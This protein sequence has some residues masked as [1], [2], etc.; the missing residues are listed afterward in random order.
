[1]KILINETFKEPENAFISIMDR[2][3]L[4]GDGVYEVI[5]YFEKGGFVGFNPHIKRLKTGL[6]LIDI[7]HPKLNDYPWRE[8]SKK[9]IDENK[10]MGDNLAIYIQVTRGPDATRSHIINPNSEPTVIM[11]PLK[12]YSIDIEATK[13]GFSVITNE[14]T[15]WNCNFIKSI[16]LLSNA[17]HKYQSQKH[18][19]EETLLVRA[20][21]AM[22]G[23]SSNVFIAKDGV[24]I[25]PPQSSNIL[26]GV[27]RLLLINALRKNN[28]KVIE[29]DIPIQNLYNADE[30]WFTSSTKE[31]VPAIKV[32]SIAIGDG[33][34]GKYFKLAQELYNKHKFDEVP[35]DDFCNYTFEWK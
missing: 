7:K 35:L 29:A 9:L 34:V 11:I 15:R 8:L 18:T 4:F 32:D 22:E 10:S 19:Q 14:D 23:S 17:M 26:S 1:M 3:F 28:L 31:L 20:G 33:K 12:E 24:I 25:T 21:K 5:S 6:S 27:T 30:V 2:G 13:K 16:S